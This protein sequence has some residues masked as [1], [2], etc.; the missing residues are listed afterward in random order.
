MRLST[1]TNG[2]G[3]LNMT[4]RYI[5]D[6][7]SFDK[8]S[9]ISIEIQ[10]RSSIDPLI[11]LIDP[12]LYDELAQVSGLII[13]SIHARFRGFFLIWKV[14]K[15]DVL[16]PILSSFTELYLKTFKLLTKIFIQNYQSSTAINAWSMLTQWLNSNQCW[17]MAVSMRDP[18]TF[19]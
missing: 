17:L 9:K 3:D 15:I 11:T 2:F 10:K 1:V 12:F 13:F 4:F 6:R 7:W 5:L 14:Y 19:K 16:I 18:H 8:S